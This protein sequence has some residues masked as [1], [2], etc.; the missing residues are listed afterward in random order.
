MNRRVR[1]PV[2]G[3]P[4]GPRVARCRLRRRLD[5]AARAGRVRARRLARAQP[6]VDDLDRRPRDHGS[7]ICA[8]APRETRCLQP[9]RGRK[10]LGLAD[11]DRQLEVLADIAHVEGDILRGSSAPTSA[12]A[13]I[14]RRPASCSSAKRAATWRKIAVERRT[15]GAHEA[16]LQLGGDQP[17]RAQDARRERHE[18]AADAELARDVDACSGPAPPNGISVKARGSWPRSTETDADRAHHVGDD[19]ARGCRAPSRAR[20]R[21]SFAPAARSPRSARRGSRRMPPPS[22]SS[23]SRPSTRLASVTVGSRPPRP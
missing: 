22:S 7:H 3:E 20:P 8:H 1:R 10:R 2:R 17:L 13:R 18:D 14:P 21:P 16:L 6:E 4:D 23:G 15:A 11:R 12:L 9:S 5:C 19:D